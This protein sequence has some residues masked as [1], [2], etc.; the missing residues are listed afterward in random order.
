[1]QPE[2]QSLTPETAQ[3]CSLHGLVFGT[4]A[5]GINRVCGLLEKTFPNSRFLTTRNSDEAHT[6]LSDSV[7]DIVVIVIE[8][9]ARRHVDLFE[10]LAN[11]ATPMPVLIAVKSTEH[12]KLIE[13]VPRAGTDWSL[14]VF[15]QT[16]DSGVIRALEQA[17]H[18]FEL[19]WERDHLQRAFKS[20]L[21]QYRNLFDEV[22]DIIFVCDRAGL[23]LDVNATA[24]RVFG[25]P[26]ESM[27]LKPVFETFGVTEELFSNLIDSATRVDGPIQDVEV[28][29]RP[30]KGNV[31]H[32]LTHIIPMEHG[33]A[34]PVRFQGVIKDITARKE[35][36]HQLRS[37][38]LKHKT[39]Y[40]LARIASSS[41]QLEEVAGRALELIVTQTGSSGAA[42]LVNQRGNELN[43]VP[44]SVPTPELCA[45][46]ESDGPSNLGRDLLG[47]WA[48]E[49]KIHR[50]DAADFSSLPNS[51][52]EWLSGCGAS[53]L[54][55]C[56]LGITNPSLPASL[57]VIAVR[58]ESAER[59]D[60]DFL[61]GVARTLEMG[62]NNCFHYAS[63]R[64]AESKFR[65]LWESSPALFF[66]VL[67][68]G[69]VFELNRTA[70][71]ALGYRVQDLIGRPFVDLI[72]PDSRAEY[73]RRHAT[74]FSDGEPHEYEIGLRKSGGELLIASVRSEPVLD[75]DGKVI[76]EKTALY[77]ITRDRMLEASLR[78]HSENLERKVEE[79]TLELRGTM[80]F[81][82]GILE[83][84]T[85]HAI[86]ALDKDGT[87]VHFNR[88]GQLLLHYDPEDLVGK[89]KLDY[90]VDL[91]SAGASDLASFLGEA[92]S[93]G[94]LVI[95]ARI[96]TGDGRTI[97]AH[98]SLNHLRSA[99]HA[100]LAFVGIA[101]DITEQK[102]LETLLT[103]YTENLQSE[104]N[105]KIRELDEKHVELIQ[106][107]KLATLGE[108]A[109]GIAHE[110]N[111]PLS[112]IRTRA[113]LLVKMVELGKGGAERIVANQREIIDLVD[114]IS[115]IVDHMRVFSRQDEQAFA[116]FSIA[117][118]IEGCLSLLGEQ[119]RLNE[120]EVDLD[121]PEDLPV[122]EGEPSQIEQV[123]LNLVANARDAMN[124]HARHLAASTSPETDE[125]RKQLRIKCELSENGEEIFLRVADNGP[126]MAEE[127]RKHIFQ[128]F[129][130]TKPVGRGTGLG[131]SISYG[132]IARHNGRIEV[133]TELGHG[134]TFTLCLPIHSAQEQ[135][136]Q[137]PPD[138]L[139]G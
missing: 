78:D 109:T 128:P 45:K 57:L 103:R 81:L 68:G 16:S 119:L 7:F 65:E 3:P 33:P 82:N 132:I 64:D 96:R 60:D 40:E 114:R 49:D 137:N 51:F 94:V 2:R 44:D 111:Q 131:L 110:L 18:R 48:I 93:K 113:Q 29:Y 46:Y 73:E 8:R 136:Q 118:S 116:P 126:G 100:N 25:V 15:D 5:N 34:M 80:Q 121:I 79:R 127:T 43:L 130:T 6:L 36:E 74:I 61:R 59:L 106:S 125:Y 1:M 90:I 115:R 67:E 56:P 32:G 38:E 24:A 19:V 17:I 112:G 123:L 99:D 95:E 13:L 12:D 104:I 70:A 41:L 22:P 31:I 47:R 92:E 30:P 89:R 77:D 54:V 42:L 83:G 91:E 50:L 26:K 139:A 53:A 75:A 28:E 84:S 117:D 107:S 55:G 62:F 76:S 97:T 27:L 9:L 135:P 85:E 21:L 138:A 129:Y 105:E 98:I 66:G 58:E 101:L 11:H 37:S 39:L 88:G 23:L 52:S 108:M 134:T 102:K 14:I 63:A 120:I 35:L 71:D 133:D 86:F 72:D 122:I 69:A 4:S 20:S 87:F 124:E 10:V